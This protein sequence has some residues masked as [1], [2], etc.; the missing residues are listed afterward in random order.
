MACSH[1]RNP[2]T[3]KAEA[4]GMWWQYQSALHRKSLAALL[5]LLLFCF[6]EKLFVLFCFKGKKLVVSV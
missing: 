5:L 6:R 3:Q 2:S 4:E 1:S